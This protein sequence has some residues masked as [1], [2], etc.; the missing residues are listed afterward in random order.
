MGLTGQLN[1]SRVCSAMH[2]SDIKINGCHGVQHRQKAKGRMVPFLIAS[3]FATVACQSLLYKSF[4]DGKNSSHHLSIKQP[5]RYS[6]HC[7][8]EL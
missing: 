4:G 5:E 1:L 7:S 6:L 8:S 3:N 2:Y